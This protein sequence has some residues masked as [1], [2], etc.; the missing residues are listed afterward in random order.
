V[1]F[2]QSGLSIYYFFHFS[3]SPVLCPFSNRMLS[4]ATGCIFFFTRLPTAPTV[5]FEAF[6]F[7]DPAVPVPHAKPSLAV[8]FTPC[9]TKQSYPYVTTGDFDLRPCFPDLFLVRFSFDLASSSFSVP[10]HPQFALE[11]SLTFSPLVPDDFFFPR[12]LKGSSVFLFAF[13]CQLLDPPF[14]FSSP[15]QN[16]TCRAPGMPVPPFVPTNV[17]RSYFP[18]F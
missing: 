15:F 6:F 8:K 10:V 18:L 11:L 2:V 5:A 13:F 3:P 17:L 4:A 9:P 14:P 7:V 16:F 1:S 12:F